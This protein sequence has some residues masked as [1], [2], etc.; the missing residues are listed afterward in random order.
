[1]PYTGELLVITYIK[2]TFLKPEVLFDASL[3]EGF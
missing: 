1:M 3:E 2:I